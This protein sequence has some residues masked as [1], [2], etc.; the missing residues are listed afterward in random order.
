VVTELHISQFAL[1]EELRIELG[2]GFTTIT[3]ETGAGKSI[4]IDALSAAVGD[5]V[6]AE[7][8]RTG[9]EQAV[10]EATFDASGAPKAL[11]AAAAA[12]VEPDADGTLILTRV[13]SAAGRHRC[14]LNGRAVPLSVL[15]EVGDRLVDIHGQHEHQALIR[16]EN[17]LQFLDGYAGGELLAVRE[18]YAQAFGELAGAKTARERLAAAARDRLREVDLLRF[19]VEEIRAAGLSVGE[20]E[21]LLATRERLAN[22]ERLREGAL[23]AHGLLTGASE[24]GLGALD[25]A[26]E[27]LRR[28]QDIAALDRGLEELAASLETAAYQL[29][30]AAGRLARY[31]DEIE[32]EPDALDEVEQ[33]LVLIQRLRR[34]Y[35]DSVADVV[36][37]GE[38]AGG[39]LAELDRADERL[40]ELATE[41]AERETEAAAL[42]E[43]LSG[44][45]ARAGRKLGQALTS[46]LGDVGMEHG[47]V[48]VELTRL[49][50]PDG[51][52]DPRGGRW[53]ADARGIDQGRFLFSANPG[54]PL[55]PLAAI[56]SGGELSRVM[57]LLK[58]VC[59][60][61]HEIPTVVFDEVDA[62]IGGQATHAVGNKLAELSR[63]TQV[64]CVTHLPQIARR[65]DQ[66]FHV[67]KATRD[68]RT[69]VSLE[70]LEHDGRVAELARMLGAREGDRAALQHAAELLE[71]G[72]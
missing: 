14:R 52:P 22:L 19:Q 16:D 13:V 70:P 17:H 9:A 12:G 27:A 2:P 49:P 32:A 5:R 57:L 10:I 71:R 58:S 53:L 40:A 42:A 69:R 7:A 50:D 25:A 59:S 15:R 23:G 26:R 8:V 28:V 60:R 3:G 66:H 31:L 47:R 11:A 62:G 1:I 37:F 33:R 44:L 20:E 61:G 35:G 65:A 30:D 63:R 67:A 36:R 51:L 68:G 43:K 45:R 24:E 48:D 18:A 41:V 64:L 38:E 4:V 54:E 46:A 39:R 72:R 34:K 6:G 29:E 56:A 21:Q 55:K